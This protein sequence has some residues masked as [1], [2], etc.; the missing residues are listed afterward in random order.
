MAQKHVRATILEKGTN[1][2]AFTDANQAPDSFKGFVKFLSESY[3]AGAL[4]ANPVLYM[5]VLHEF[6]TSAV[7][8]TV[9][10]D[11]IGSMVVTCSI[12]GQQIEFNEQDVNIALG[13]PNADLVEVPT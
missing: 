9:V 4:T 13:V 8:R 5:D 12:G 11:N 10:N 6:W 1:Y 2:I 7:F 3:I